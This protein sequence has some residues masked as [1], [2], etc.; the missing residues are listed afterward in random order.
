[1]LP[2]VGQSVKIHVFGYESDIGRADILYTSLLLQMA[3]A[4]VRVHVPGTGN[5]AN[6]ARDAGRPFAV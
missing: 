5:G 2:A 3:H 1:M 6:A 4:L